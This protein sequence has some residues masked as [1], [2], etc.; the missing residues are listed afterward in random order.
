V[1]HTSMPRRVG[2]AFSLVVVALVALHVS[3][4]AVQAKGN[5]FVGASGKTLVVSGHPWRFVGFNDYQL[6]SMP[7]G[8]YFC[9]RP[10]G[11]DT[12][13]SVLEDAKRSGATAIRT[14]FFQS[15]Y[16]LDARGAPARATWNA[17]DRVLNRAT[18][19]GLKVVPVLMNEW[20]DCEPSAADKGLA[21][22]QG[23]FMQAGTWG[24][25]LSFMDY[26]TTVARHYAKRASIAFWQIG[27]EVEAH[28]SSSCDPPTESVAA[29]ALRGFA[30]TM[31]AAITRAD[32]NHLV[33]L[34]TI[35][36]GQCGLSGTDYQYVNAGRVGICDY[37]DYGSPTQAMP[38]DGY[39]RLA[40]RIAQCGLLDKPIVVTES[41][42]PADVGPT[43]LE[44]GS[45]TA[46]TLQSRAA[47]FRA[48]MTA[49]FSSGVS[50]YILWEKE[51]DASNSSENAV[52]H[53]L[54]EIGPN[55]LDYDPTNGVSAAAATGLGASRHRASTA[56]PASARP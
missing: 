30:D 16:D 32:P 49:A 18:A 20:Q 14:W 23:G 46:A 47:F 45:V 34:G 12:L 24:Y 25:P 10:T 40:Q 39:N 1:K 37:H 21:F 52:D 51:Q 53:G 6:T 43:G 55:S 29:Q 13:D 35:G 17:F 31:T 11:N 50:G 33:S 2:G 8:A 5:P 3:T 9:G 54:Y 44:V 15:F 27:N 26:A 19:Y 4:P 56:T 42:I 36:G 38:D 48:K 22:Y 7:N 41:G 28:P